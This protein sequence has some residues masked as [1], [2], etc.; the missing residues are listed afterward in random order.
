MKTTKKTPLVTDSGKPRYKAYS[1]KQLQ[2][3]LS[4]TKTPKI[5]HKIRTELQR[6]QIN[7][8]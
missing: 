4:K 7:A 3:E 5:L 2:E 6:K 8:Q 1:I